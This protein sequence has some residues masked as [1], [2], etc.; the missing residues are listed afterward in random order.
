LDIGNF[1]VSTIWVGDA[2]FVSFK[3]IW[4]VSSQFLDF[5]G[6]VEVGTGISSILEF[7]SDRD[8]FATIVGFVEGLDWIV[9]T[10][11]E[12]KPI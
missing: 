6:S 7:N 10:L 2:D 4:H 1:V 12:G 5:S 8:V 3:Y 11:G 9:F